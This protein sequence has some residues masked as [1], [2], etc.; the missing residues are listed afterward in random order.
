MSTYIPA[1]GKA[2]SENWYFYFAETPT[3]EQT[4][5]AAVWYKDNDGNVRVAISE[6]IN[7]KKP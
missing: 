1:N 6:P 2:C 5:Y 4:G 7:L 3:E